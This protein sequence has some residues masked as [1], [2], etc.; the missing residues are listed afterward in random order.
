MKGRIIV[1]VQFRNHWKVR[2]SPHEDLVE[3][4]RTSLEAFK[5]DPRV[6]H[7]H[8]LEE[9]MQ[10]R[11]AFWINNKY[12]VVYKLQGDDVLLVDIGTHEQVYLR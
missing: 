1:S 6:V 5:T 4:Y 12:R 7:D 8:A 2:I 9:P 3:D 11:R 10:D